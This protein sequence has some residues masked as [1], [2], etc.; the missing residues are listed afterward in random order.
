VIAHWDQVEPRT[1]EFE[2][3]R[4]T[5]FDLGRAAGTVTVGLRRYRLDPGDYPT[6][7]HVHGAEEEI[8]YVL[9]GEG[10][11]WQDGETYEIRA[12]DCIVHRAA[13][14]AHTIVAGDEGLDVLVF[15][16]RVPVEVGYLPR[17][18]AA[19]LW[20][21][22]VET[23]AA[24]P[25]EYDWSSGP[26]PWHREA[27]AGELELPPPK[28]RPPNIVNVE[29]VLESP[30]HEGASVSS[31]WRDVGRAIGSRR[32][33]LKHVRV[34]RGKLGVPPHCHSAE[35][36]IFVVL[37]GDGWLELIPSPHQ[38]DE[39]VKEERHG[40]RRGSVVARPAGTRIA[41]TFGA[42]PAG[43]TY[44]AYGTRDPNDVAYYPRSRKLFWRGLGVIGR[45]EHLDYWDGED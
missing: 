12:G 3:M 15:G 11:S 44:L 14:E 22:W 16:M 35:E 9:E 24:L 34:S 43:L 19:W 39:S 29:D 26:E 4:F 30:L 32:T 13:E 33:G 6:P 27:A 31:Y 25:W 2:P 42:G 17:A 8:F 40:V 18:G 21:T 7:P 20:P 37:E 41:H 28:P 23:P 36:E 10:L 1:R 38:R 45:I 5:A